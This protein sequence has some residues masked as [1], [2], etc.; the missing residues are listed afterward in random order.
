MH[1]DNE[2]THEQKPL[3]IS[4]ILDQGSAGLGQYFSRA[5]EQSWGDYAL[6]FVGLGG[7]ATPP[8]K[9]TITPSTKRTH[10]PIL[11]GHIETDV[12]YIPS[13]EFTYSPTDPANSKN[14]E[15]KIIFTKENLEKAFTQVRTLPDGR[16]GVYVSEPVLF[17]PWCEQGGLAVTLSMMFGS[18]YGDHRL[19]MIFDEQNRLQDINITKVHRGAQVLFCAKNLISQRELSA[20][21]RAAH[22]AIEEISNAQ[23]EAS[24]FTF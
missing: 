9:L 22:Q 1:R 11:H 15:D 12:R 17:S 8:K 13:I 7:T 14:R 16:R 4:S 19:A 10:G 6:S 18:G 20:E 24:R 23:D 21:R 5:I 2:G 3:T